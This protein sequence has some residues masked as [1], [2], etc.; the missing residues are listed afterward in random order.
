MRTFF[1]A[2][3]IVRFFE[4][5]Q[6]LQNT[7]NIYDTNNGNGVTKGAL[8]VK[9]TAGNREIADFIIITLRVTNYLDACY[10][11]RSRLLLLRESILTI[12]MMTSFFSIHSSFCCFF[13]DELKRYRFRYKNECNTIDKQCTSIYVSG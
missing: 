7:I 12:I 2:L 13:V 3:F 8:F 6:K 10:L 11:E 1:F 9:C 5:K 4:E